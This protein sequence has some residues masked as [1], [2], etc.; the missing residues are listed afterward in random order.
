MEMQGLELWNSFPGKRLRI[1]HLIHL[2]NEAAPIQTFDDLADTACDLLDLCRNSGLEVGP[3]SKM[4]ELA[5]GAQNYTRLEK[6]IARVN[7]KLS[8]PQ[9]GSVDAST[10]S[11]GSAAYAARHSEPDTSSV[12]EPATVAEPA[13]LSRIFYGSWPSQI[14]GRDKIELRTYIKL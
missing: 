14:T 11:H 9:H 13:I 2:A 3:E 4:I 7:A 8:Q 10:A 5:I 1:D 6:L 12:A